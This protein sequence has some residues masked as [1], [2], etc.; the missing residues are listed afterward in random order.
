MVDAA[1]DAR[2]GEDD[3]AAAAA[4]AARLEAAK[5]AGRVE[6]RALLREAH[7]MLRERGGRRA[8]DARMKTPANPDFPPSL[9]LERSGFV[10]GDDLVILDDGTV[11]TTKPFSSSSGRRGGR[12]QPYE[13]LKALEDAFSVEHDDAELR[14]F[15]SEMS[16]DMEAPTGYEEG[17]YVLDDGTLVHGLG[18]TGGLHGPARDA[19]AFKVGRSLP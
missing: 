9:S 7:R 10:F 4:A 5:E 3:R 12:Y 14:V 15:G 16:W 1:R 2:R 11:L 8:L 6:L 18:D 17:F 13:E 19:I